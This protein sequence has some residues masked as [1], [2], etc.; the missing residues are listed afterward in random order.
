VH[1]AFAQVEQMD[2]WWWISTLDNKP[3]W[4]PEL[5]VRSVRAITGITL[6]PDRIWSIQWGT[7]NRYDT[8]GP[9]R[10]MVRLHTGQ[11]HGSV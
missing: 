2:V 7:N 9:V 10:E 4:T 11:L 8:S 3:H 5:I 6:P 1:P